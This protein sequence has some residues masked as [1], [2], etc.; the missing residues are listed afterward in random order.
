MSVAE[1]HP[2][3][4]LSVPELRKRN[5]I[6]LDLCTY[7][8]ESPGGATPGC[9]GRRSKTPLVMIKSN[10]DTPSSNTYRSTTSTART[11]NHRA[12]GLPT[13]PI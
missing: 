4:R 9:P 7:E 5:L 2:A 3:T 6:T 1:L 12:S 13:L 8:V 10:T 11:V